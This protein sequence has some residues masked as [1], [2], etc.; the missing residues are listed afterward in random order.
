MGKKGK[1]GNLKWDAVLKHVA[2]QQAGNSSMPYAG[3]LSK[4]VP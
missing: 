1:F 3:E 2:S 4:C